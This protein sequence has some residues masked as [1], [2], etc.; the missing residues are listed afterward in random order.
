MYRQRRYV[1]LKKFRASGRKCFHSNGRNFHQE[2]EESINLRMLGQGGD[3]A[4]ISD[5]RGHS[6]VC[7]LSQ[8][9]EQLIGDY[10][11]QYRDVSERSDIVEQC[12]LIEVDW[13]GRKVKRDLTL[14]FVHFH[15]TCARRGRDPPFSTPR[16][17]PC[18]LSTGLG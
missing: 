5:K 6:L 7:D 9:V 18:F 15:F 2:E 1:S 3:Q 10:E 14:G 4:V 13:C 8:L 17:P 12:C 11:Y 16:W